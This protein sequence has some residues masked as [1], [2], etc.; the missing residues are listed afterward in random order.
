MT[1]ERLPGIC[2]KDEDLLKDILELIFRLMVDI[3]D[4]VE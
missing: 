2:Q 4:D 1:I 3:D